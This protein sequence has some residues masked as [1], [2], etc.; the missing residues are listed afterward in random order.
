MTQFYST[1]L[2]D[3]FVRK[4]RE[5]IDNSKAEIQET[6]GLIIDTE[7]VTTAIAEIIDY[8]I[9]ARD[10]FHVSELQKDIHLGQDAELLSSMAEIGADMEDV[11]CTARLNL[12]LF[13]ES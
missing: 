1:I 8:Y 13:F 6:T 9:M 12:K 2:S 7:S 11:F 10:K 3:E 4:I 5:F